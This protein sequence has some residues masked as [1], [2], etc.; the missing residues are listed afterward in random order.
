MGVKQTWC[1][2]WWKPGDFIINPRWARRCD[3]HREL[4]TPSTLRR[5]PQQRRTLVLGAGH[6]FGH[7]DFS[8]LGR[9]EN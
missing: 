9:A 4:G 3:R 8:H 7:I 5:F 6:G 2:G 1:V